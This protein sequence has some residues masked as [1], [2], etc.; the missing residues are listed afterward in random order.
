MN[1][2]EMNESPQCSLPLNHV[3][4]YYNTCFKCIWKQEEFLFENICL[5]FSRAKGT[6]I[7]NN[8]DKNAQ[9]LSQL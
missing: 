5:F 1:E 6:I 4:N 7:E 9:L 8:K 2:K 3:I